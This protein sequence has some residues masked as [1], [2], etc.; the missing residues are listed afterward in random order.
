MSVGVPREPAV[1]DQFNW[2]DER[3]KLV[4]IDATRNRN[5]VAQS[6]QQRDYAFVGQ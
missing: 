4:L 2:T 1:F 3:P 5:V 6:F